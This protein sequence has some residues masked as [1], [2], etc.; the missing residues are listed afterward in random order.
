MERA[1]ADVIKKVEAEK[2]S[3]DFRDSYLA[4]LRH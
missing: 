3:L 2:P 4:T 1:A